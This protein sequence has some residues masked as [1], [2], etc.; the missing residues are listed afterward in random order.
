MSC[1]FVTI[2]RRRPPGGASSSLRV[3]FLSCTNGASLIPR[4]A[5][6]SLEAP[7][8][9]GLGKAPGVDA[10]SDSAQSQP[11]P[12]SNPHPLALHHRFKIHDDRA[13]R[14]H[15]RSNPPPL[16]PLTPWPANQASSPR[17]PALTF[18]QRRSAELLSPC[19]SPS[20]EENFPLAKTSA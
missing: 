1:N 6:G 14:N 3:Y 5:S 17:V 16:S 12:L 11:T 19:C 18:E 9:A 2:R 20:S 15:E 4:S 13:C 10:P 8:A 7:W